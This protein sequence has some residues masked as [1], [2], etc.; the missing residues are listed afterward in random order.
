[1]P[2]E[3]DGVVPRC[4]PTA[5]D[6]I[7]SPAKHPPSF[8]ASASHGPF[9]FSLVVFVDIGL[10]N[11]GETTVA[12]SVVPILAHLDMAIAVLEFNTGLVSITVW[13]PGKPQFKIQWGMIRPF[14][15]AFITMLS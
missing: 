5:E 14:K 7:A 10:A 11:K 6:F 9:I 15:V 12:V 8:F 4:L 3:L 1:M 2:A 13:L